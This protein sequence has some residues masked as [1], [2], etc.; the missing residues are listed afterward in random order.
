VQ[1]I[2][3]RIE[4]LIR[5]SAAI[6]VFLLA[7]EFAPRLGLI[8]RTF[9]PPFSEVVVRGAQYAWAGKLLPQI[10]VSVG[11]AA[12][13]F[14]L[15]VVTAVPLGILLGWYRPLEAYLNPLLQ[16]LRQ[17]NPV[18]LFPAFILFFGIG[19]A[20]NIAIIYWVVVW[21]ILLGTV[22]GVRQADPALV[23]YA[24]S[25]VLPDWQIFA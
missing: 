25:V 14:G 13:G 21:P 18:S 20:T 4:P 2:W 5:S 23:K 8:N 9:L 16:L 24:R 10:L 1:P 12:G 22:N 11:R 19:Y 3:P 6:V 17:T 7:W 15:G